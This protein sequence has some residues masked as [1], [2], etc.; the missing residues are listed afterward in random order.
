MSRCCLLI[1]LDGL[2]D[3]A[4]AEFGDRTPLEAA[5]TPFMDALAARG[6]N[7]LF[8]AIRPGISLPSENA[9]FSIFGY[10]PDEFP[11]RGYLEA[12]GAGVPMGQEDVAILAHFVSVNCLANTLQLKKHRPQADANETECF[13]Q[14]VASFQSNGIR[15]HYHQTHG[16]DGIVV[17]SGDVDAA[18]TDSDPLE[19]HSYL[20][21]V[22]PWEIKKDSGASVNTAMVLRDY[23]VWSHKVLA[24]H[25]LNK[26][27]EAAG[28]EPV[29]ALVTQRAGKWKPVECLLDRWG[30][31]STSI[32]SGI[33]YW[34][35]SAFL[36][37]DTVKVKDSDNPGRDLAERLRLALRMSSDYEFVHIHTKVPDV[38]AHSKNP[39]NKV[40]AIESLDQG[41]GTVMDELLNDDLTVIVTADHSTPS[42]GSLVHSGEPVP[43]AVVGNGI[44]KDMVTAFDEVSCAGGALGTFRGEDFM[45]LVLNWLDKAKLQGM[46]D[47]P[48]NQPYWPGKR[49]PLLIHK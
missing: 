43:F 40:A 42:S 1:L 45:Y 49:V 28:K 46:M 10:T 38:A 15:V 9:H 16:L 25:P 24:K 2:G 18:V 4:Y 44:R 20:L 23:L 27:R 11:G 35:L 19:L 26:K 36:G 8:W 6:S 12:V 21:K 37:M 41:L 32:S 29:N 31:K 33:M 13:S 14:A 7:G 30:L 47:T 5:S 34:G 22:E 48:K 17:L 39:S 3:R